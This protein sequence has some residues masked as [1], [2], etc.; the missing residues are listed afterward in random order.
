MTFPDAPLDVR[1][2]LLILGAWADVT[3]WLDH[4]PVSTGRGHPDESTT[5]SPS[6]QHLT[7]SNT[8][9]RFSAQ[10]PTSPYYPWLVRNTQCRI[11]VPSDQPY[12]RLEMT[13]GYASCPWAPA[14][15]ITGD[16]DARIDV[17]LTDWTGCE[18]CGIW[19]SP[20]SQS[21]VL[22]LDPGGWPRLYWST[23]GSDVRS[24]RATARLPAGRVVLRA[25]LAVATGTVTFYT[26]AG[27]GADAGPWTQLGSPA[28]TG[29]TSVYAAGVQLAAGGAVG[30]TQGMYGRVYEMELRSGI[31]GTV[32]ARPVFS[33]QAPYVTSFVD[34]EGNT[35]RGFSTT[36]AST[37]EITD[38]D[39]RAH[40]EVPEWPQ[41]A[42]PVDP[43]GTQPR[44]VTVPVQG[45]GLLRRL[46]QRNNAV[47]SAMR[48]AWTITGTQYLAGYWP[49]EDGAGAQSLAS[50]TG[51][52]AAA[53]SGALQLGANSDFACSAALPVIS[54]ATIVARVPAW[55]GTWSGNQVSWLME[56]PSA[57]E[58]NGAEMARVAT[59]GTIA[60]AVITYGTGG[61]LTVKMLSAS[62][63]VLAS[64]SSLAY[65]VDGQRL[66]VVLSL[67]P[68]GA[69]G[70]DW[71]LTYFNAANPDF[72][73]FQATGTVAS[74]SVG[75]VASVTIC[76]GGQLTGTVFGHLAVQAAA[77]NAAQA[78]GPLGAWQGE[79]AGDRF[80]RLC[81]EEGVQFRGGGDLSATIA[82]GA[83]SRQTL[84][85]LL[86]ECADASRGTWYELRQQL[87]WGFIPP[88]GLYNQPAAVALTYAADNIGE[89][90]ADPVEDD[91]AIVNDV[92]VSQS[93]GGTSARQ[94]AAPGQPVSGGRLSTLPPPSG[95]GTYDDSQSY[96]VWQASDLASIAAWMVHVG[97]ADEPRYPGLVLDLSNRAL[98][99]LYWQLL[100]LDIG[101]R[102][103]VSSPPGYL[104]PNPVSQLAVQLD[105]EIWYDRHVIT[106][107]GVPSRP[108]LVAQEG[109]A[110][111]RADTDGSTLAGAATATA[112]T[113]SVA[114]AAGVPLWATGS[115]LSADIS[116]AGERMTVTAI[117]GSSSP[118]SFTV[119]RSVNGVVK[120]QASGV[121]VA[122]WDSPV[123]AL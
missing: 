22:A 89:W 91:Q 74:A 79:A 71:T 59:G 86:Q 116:V 120:S 35:W 107:T 62:G 34:A 76:G 1:A 117:S 73:A 87:G 123:A 97:T 31:G 60:H 93:S 20:G 68:D 49:M 112:T 92:T 48:R 104:G 115:G 42:P 51:G 111:G 7:L 110:T 80:A 64:G 37:Q 98:A 81:E 26:A 46:S 95:A 101:R 38:R 16:L 122:L 41:H 36:P 99:P 77:D 119:T 90:A 28:V 13:P 30:L 56:V 55:G 72:S 14:L 84:A 52:P 58:F 69:G 114:T 8:D 27:G 11:S 103:T 102:L 43:G 9:Y 18:L 106:M 94:Y 2:E 29:A 75:P 53:F 82:M 3:P 63:S 5:V 109:A 44:A 40:C 4:G 57:G 54:E 25:A 32:V 17:Q 33:A 105:E 10:N 113:L 50:G 24:A 21:W 121:V 39:Y 66:L 88:G 118:Q 85:S 19:G 65:D 47:S 45:G 78:G 83:Q 96:N 100:A 67:S 70:I 15:G 23:T 61:L 6:T 108:W 12:L